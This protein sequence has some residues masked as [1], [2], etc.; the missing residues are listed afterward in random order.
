MQLGW[1]GGVRRLEHVPAS[2]H[3]QV[4]SYSV[5][6]IAQVAHQRPLQVFLNT[7]VPKQCTP[8]AGVLRA[9]P[10]HQLGPRQR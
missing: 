5:L 8:E 1:A 3:E 7:A 2:L 10:V 6:Q 9:V 4:P